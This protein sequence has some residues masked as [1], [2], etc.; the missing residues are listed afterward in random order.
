VSLRVDFLKPTPTG[1]VLELRGRV[2]ER[3]NRKAIVSVT[4][5]AEGEIRASGEVVLVLLQGGNVK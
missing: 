2:K 3:T 5:S 4:L 1:K